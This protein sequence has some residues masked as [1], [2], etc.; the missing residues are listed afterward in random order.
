MI[1]ARVEEDAEVILAES[2]RGSAGS[3]YYIVFRDF[4]RL[5]NITIFQFLSG[6]FKMFYLCKT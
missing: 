4:E 6:S 3:P 5:E 2:K 1:K